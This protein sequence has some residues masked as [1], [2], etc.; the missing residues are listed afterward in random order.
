MRDTGKTWRR[1]GG[2]WDVVSMGRKWRGWEGCRMG[3]GTG[4]WRVW[5]EIPEPTALCEPPLTILLPSIFPSIHAPVP[6][7]PPSK[8]SVLCHCFSPSPLPACTPVSS[9]SMAVSPEPHPCLAHGSPLRP[10]LLNEQMR[11]CLYGDQGRVPSL[12]AWTLRKWQGPYGTVA[13]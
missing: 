9:K 10:C 7:H 12:H 8:S 2:W 4:C 13:C 3:R 5:R 6:F 1:G 11:D